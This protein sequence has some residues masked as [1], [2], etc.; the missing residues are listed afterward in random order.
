MENGD[1]GARRGETVGGFEAEKAAADDDDARTRGVRDGVDVVDVAEGEHARR[2]HSGDGELDRLRAGRKD[3]LGKRQSRAAR[4]RHFAR[5]GIDRGRAH[6]VAQGHAAVAPPSRWFELDIAEA[7]LLGQQCRQEYPIVSEPRL[8]ADDG[9]CV[10]AERALGQ[11]LDQTRRGHAVADDDERLAHRF[12]SRFAKCA[13][14]RPAAPC[15]LVEKGGGSR[16]PS[17]SM[18][19]WRSHF[20]LR[21]TRAG[22]L[23]PIYFSRL[24]LCDGYANAPAA[25]CIRATLIVCARLGPRLLRS[26]DGG[27]CA[28]EAAAAALETEQGLRDL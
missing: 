6:A 8:V 11:F 25:H 19:T 7:D 28:R 4:Q 22:R 24:E 23:K 17:S 12:P 13:P 2:I 16:S 26:M 21:A 9:N 14:L 20:K 18:V 10:A 27:G 15:S 1:V 5:D 3:E